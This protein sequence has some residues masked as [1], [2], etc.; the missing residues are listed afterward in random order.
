MSIQK[1]LRS[2]KDARDKLVS[3]AAYKIACCV[4]RHD[5]A[6]QRRASLNINGLSIAAVVV[7]IGEHLMVNGNHVMMFEDRVVHIALFYMAATRGD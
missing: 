3:D 4:H 2:A 6:T 1:H 5:E 7:T